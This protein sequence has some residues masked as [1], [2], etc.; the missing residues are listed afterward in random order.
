MDSLASR[1]QFP[2]Q[3]QEMSGEC[4]SRPPFKASYCT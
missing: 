2:D 4:G 3:R 1:V